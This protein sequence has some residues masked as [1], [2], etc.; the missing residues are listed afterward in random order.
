MK[1]IEWVPF[2]L[3]LVGTVGLLMNE[4]VFAWGTPATLVF[5]AANTVGLVL[6]GFSYW[7]KKQD[8]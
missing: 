3:L 2:M 1:Q 4:F 5:G 6:L 7:G 8:R